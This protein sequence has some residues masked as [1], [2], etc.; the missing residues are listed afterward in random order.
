[1]TNLCLNACT[2]FQAHGFK[3]DID[4]TSQK[5]SYNITKLPNGNWFKSTKRS[6][7]E[8]AVL[9]A[10]DLNSMPAL[11]ELIEA[12]DD[13]DEEIKKDGGRVFISE[14]LA[15]KIKKGTQT[16]LLV[17]ENNEKQDGRYRKLCDE[18]IEHG[19]ER[20]RF[21][22]EETYMLTKSGNEWSITIGHENHS[23]KKIGL[24]L[25]K[26][27]QLKILTSKIM[28]TDSKFQVNGGRIF[29]TPTRIYRLNN[30]VE[31]IL[32]L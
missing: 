15:Y 32:K 13:L 14:Y 8:A 7:H 9:T 19:L 23:G 28:K 10:L 17:Y 24:D 31:M 26:M 3:K 11:K 4:P 21:R 1:M 16:V 22:T 18:M 12:L 30:K 5:E 20:D 6:F 2:E 27:P 25:K 29:I